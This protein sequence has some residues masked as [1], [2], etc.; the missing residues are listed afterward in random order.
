MSKDTIDKLA[1]LGS[2]TEEHLAFVEEVGRADLTLT[3]LAVAIQVL[4]RV[5]L[6]RSQEDLKAMRLLFH[7]IAGEDRA[8]WEARAEYLVD[9]AVGRG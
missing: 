2:R 1:A 7:E 6:E 8:I 3:A 9:G 5:P 4:G